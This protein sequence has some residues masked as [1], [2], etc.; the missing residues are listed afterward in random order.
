MWKGLLKKDDEVP[1]LLITAGVMFSFLHQ[2]SLGTLYILAGQKLKPLWH[3]PLLPVL[4]LMSAMAAGVAMVSME[5]ILTDRLLKHESDRHLLSAFVSRMPLILCLYLLLK[6]SDILS[7]NLPRDHFTAGFPA[8][9]WWVE[10]IGG[11]IIPVVLYTVPKAAKTKTGIFIASFLVVAG[12][13]L[14]RINVAII[15]INI[16]RWERYYPSLSELLI[17]LGIISA[18]IMAFVWISGIFPIHHKKAEV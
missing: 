17:T 9:S 6:V 8:F 13:V 2:S 12:V 1:I 10:I 3:S 14:N 11:V 18:G 5:A 16:P 4:F 7:R 15:G